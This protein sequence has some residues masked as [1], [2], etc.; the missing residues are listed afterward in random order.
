MA[1]TTTIDGQR[2]TLED[3]TPYTIRLRDPDVDGTNRDLVGRY[4]GRSKDGR[5]HFDID[6][7][8]GAFRPKDILAIGEF[9]LVIGGETVVSTRR[10]GE[11]ASAYLARLEAS[12][13]AAYVRWIETGPGQDALEAA[14]REVAAARRETTRA[15]AVILDGE[16]VAERRRPLPPPPGRCGVCKRRTRRAVCA[17]GHPEVAIG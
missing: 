1:T 3:D 2:V 5:L 7:V 16:V 6:G 17:N 12:L 14:R 13:G 15:S 4:V 9:T 8:R 10:P 11:T